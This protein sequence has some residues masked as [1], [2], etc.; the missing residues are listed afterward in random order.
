[1]KLNLQ[2]KIST[3]GEEVRGGGMSKEGDALFTDYFD[4]ESLNV[5]K[6]DD[7]LKYSMPLDPS[8]GYDITFVDENTVAITSGHLSMK[9]GIDII[10]I[11][12]R[13][14]INFI[15]LPDRTYGVSIGQQLLVSNEDQEY[16][17]IIE[18]VEDASVEQHTL[19][20]NDDKDLEGIIDG[21]E[22]AF[23]KHDSPVS[24]EDKDQN[25]I[26]C[27]VEDVSIEQ[28]FPI[29]NDELY[30]DG[31]IDGIGDVYGAQH[32]L[33]YKDDDDFKEVEEITECVEEQTSFA[34]E[35]DEERKGKN[36]AIE[37]M[38]L[39]TNINKMQTKVTQVEKTSNRVQLIQQKEITTGGKEIRG[40]SMSIDGNLLFTDY[41]SEKMLN[42]AADGTLKHKMTTNFEAF[43]FTFVNANT[44]A[45]T[46]GESNL[47]T[48]I[49][50]IDVETRG[51]IQFITLLGRPF[52]ITC[53]E[54]SLFVCVEKFGIYK[55]D[56]VNYDRCCVI[57]CCLPW[58]SYIH[59]SSYR[60]YYTDYTVHSVYCCNRQ[61]SPFWTFR[62]DL[63]LKYPRGIT[64]DND[65]N[66]Y[67]VG[68]KSSN[69]VIISNDGK[70]ILTTVEG[71]NEPSSIFFNQQ[72]R[73]LL[74]ANKRNN[75]FLYTFK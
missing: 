61:G 29:S 24:N 7:T 10:N 69:V 44:V 20:H 71:L 22:D 8:Y 70:Q 65:G 27:S 23:I 46:S 13:S 41:E 59:V 31:I 14:K 5:I 39:T 45:I 43:D 73:S 28:L 52:G 38:S 16:D 75:A 19:V 62:K 30:P 18:G 21:V 72:N 9:T 74:V 32:S 47:H 35:D 63:I 42:I 3:Y 50:L 34:S 2:K 33:V 64:V 51:E 58:Y 48:G 60:I 57:R 37:D 15:N 40:C 26:V 55:F 6:S 4:N 68:E 17:G 1:M 49:A 53:D 67:V 66:V 36:D 12:N 25:G 54:D 56:T 11:K